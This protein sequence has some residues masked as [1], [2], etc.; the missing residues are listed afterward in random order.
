MGIKNDQWVV[1]NDQK[2]NLAVQK[3]TSCGEYG[4]CYNENDRSIPHWYIL[5]FLIL[6]SWA[7]V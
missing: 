6:F 7:L 5:Y 1:V 4:I 2:L 3:K